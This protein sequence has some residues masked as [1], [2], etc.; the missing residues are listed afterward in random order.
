[1]STKGRIF[2]IQRFSIHDGPG[3]RTTVFLKG[4][5]LRCAWC[6]NPESIS[7]KDQISFIPEKCIGC[8]YCFKVCPNTAHAMVDARHVLDRSRC[9]VCG[10]CVEQCYSGALELVGRDVT[11]DEV[12]EE[13]MADEPFYETSG[14]GMTLSGGEPLIQINFTEAT[15][16][17]AKEHGL[18]CCLDTCGFVDF[19]CF[20]RVMPYVDLFLYDVKDTNDAR[21]RINTG[22][23]N[24][25]I[26]ENL[27]ALHDCGARILARMPFIPGLNDHED[28]LHGM[29]ELMLS[30][31]NLEG[32]ELMPYHK[33]GLSKL[34]RFGLPSPAAERIEP[35]E[36]SLER[37]IGRLK[38]AGVNLINKS[39]K[40]T[41]A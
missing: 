36:D 13:V 33:L 8:G 3:I 34:D 21:H 29:T 24:A 26:L 16:K 19:A 15:L 22:V 6:H 35:D 2:N 17:A 1:M 40:E 41:A 7:S 14:G 38:A 20:E 37:W 5:P 12:L 23:P 32:F 10:K 25:R 18:H 39:S 27:R 31:P 28:N 11:V 30:L 4:C 9:K